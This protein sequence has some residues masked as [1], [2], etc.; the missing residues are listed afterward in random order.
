MRTSLFP[1][2]GAWRPFAWLAGL[3]AVLLVL[4]GC[5]GGDPLADS[6][7][8]AASG[9]SSDT[10]TV[11]SA[12]F[13]ESEVIGELYAGVLRHAGFDVNTKPGIGAREAYVGAVK[14]GSVD[15]V[16]DY[17]GNLLLFAKPD[18]TQSS[19]QDILDALPE[20]LKGE[21]LSVLEAS[22]AEDK[23]SLVVTKGTADKYSL[24]SIG[25]L[26][27]VCG[28]LTMG[29]PPEFQERAYGVKGLK[30][31]YD[32]TFKSFEP[33]NDGAGPLTVQALIK[34]DV[35][36]ADLF[37]TNPAIEDNQLVVLEDPEDNFIAQQALPLTAPDRLPQKAVDALNELSG[38]LTT[39]DLV[40]LN[41]KISGDQQLNP[42]D[43]AKQWLSDHGY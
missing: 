20:A 33:I 24:S 43:A 30:S 7:G 27:P 35:Q 6:G 40:D 10:I 16:P 29:G 36:V 19:A 38:K 14:D 34:G 32:C 28:E 12:N 1:R 39:A 4:A 9:G 37:T 13:P 2:S 41:R 21:G 23:D 22:Q 25:D 11:G 15:V 8:D 31:K 42:A 17:S 5:G 3:C 18:A 26:A